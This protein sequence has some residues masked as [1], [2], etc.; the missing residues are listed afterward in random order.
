MSFEGSCHCGKVAYTVEAELPTGAMQCNCSHCRRKGFLLAFFPAEQFTLD[1]GE[2]DLQSYLFYKH[3]IE[4]RFC[5]TCGTQ[6]FAIGTG[7][8]GSQMAAINLR[9]V[10]A[11]D[12]DALEIQKVDGASF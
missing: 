5:T 8:D 1:R 3:K 4:H 10:P 6:S 2:A 9:C 7:P 11:A 12:L